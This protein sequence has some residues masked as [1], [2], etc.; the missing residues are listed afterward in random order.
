MKAAGVFDF[1]KREKE[2]EVPIV[3]QKFDYIAQQID[4]QLAG[5]PRAQH[6]QILE[7]ALTLWKI[8]KRDPRWVEIV[9]RL[10]NYKSKPIP[11]GTPGQQDIWIG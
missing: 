1:L 7:K 2:P 3:E 5:Q 10:K 11:A 6:D 9:M 8:N 4:K